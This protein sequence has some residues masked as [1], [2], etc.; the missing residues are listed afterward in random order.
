M[1]G[2]VRFGVETTAAIRQGSA[3]GMILLYTDFGYT[4][5]YLGQV[6]MVLQREAPDVPVVDLMCDA[7]TWTPRAAGILLG[8]LAAQIRPGDV[9]LGVVDPGVGTERRPVVWLIDERWYVGPDNGLFDVVCGRGV[10]VQGWEVTWRPPCCSASFHG[11]DLFAPVAASI[12]QGRRPAAVPLRG[13]P[14]ADAVL[15]LGEIIYVDHFG[16]AMTGLGAAGVPRHWCL[17]AAGRV[18]DHAR[19]FA[20]APAGILFWYENSLGLVEIAANR[21]P[22][23]E[24]LGLGIGCPVSWQVPT[25]SG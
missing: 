13:G 12:A 24:L 3:R 21:A 10:K 20:E 2:L 11:R 7:P 14:P 9:C 16:N 15:E 18:L 22:A 25:V 19:T 8:A 6:R 5:P 1:P 23:A 17:V 4:G